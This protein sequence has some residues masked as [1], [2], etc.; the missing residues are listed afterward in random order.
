MSAI[1]ITFGV[2]CLVLGALSS[3]FADSFDQTLSLRGVSFHVTCAN[4]GSINALRIEPQGL[5]KDNAVILR[6][7]EG[8]VSGA[9]I[10]DLNGD[11]SP[12]IYVYVTSAG[13]GSYGSLVAY[14][15]NRKKSLTEIYMPPL[16]D[17]PKVS[18]GYMGHDEFAVVE[19][20]FV[21]RFPIYQDQ[22]TN[23]K[24]TSGK[25]RQIQY[26]LKAGESGWILSAYR[27]IDF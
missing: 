5:K 17:D 2:L 22:D 19:S 20:A 18:K 6:E 14:A 13:S 8:T 23:A 10:G 15:A 16:E 11:G 27:V 4:Q 12:E 26:H 7:I 24:P 1:K 3:A 25:I 9:E 21:R